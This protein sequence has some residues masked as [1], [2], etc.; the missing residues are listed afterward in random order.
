M[1]NRKCEKGKDCKHFLIE[2][3]VRELGGLGNENGLK[4]IKD[5]EEF[6]GFKKKVENLGQLIVDFESEVMSFFDAQGRYPCIDPMEICWGRRKYLA[7]RKIL[8]EKNYL[9]KK[10][11]R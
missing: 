4:K 10:R 3:L 1:E 2:K 8:R 9:F 6:N 11:W 7:C 5:S